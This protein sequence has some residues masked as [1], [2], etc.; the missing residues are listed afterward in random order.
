MFPFP[1]SLRSMPDRHSQ[2]VTSQAVIQ[3]H[4]TSPTNPT[5]YEKSLAASVYEALIAEHQ[6]R[7]TSEQSFVEL[8]A[9]ARWRQMRTWTMQTAALETG[10]AHQ[11]ENAGNSDPVRAALAFQNLADTSNALELLQRYE[12]SFE[13]QYN[14]SLNLLL[15]LRALQPAPV[16]PPHR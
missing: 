9:I 1:P 11:P 15:K 6:P 7:T 3:S 5:L 16:N 2:P 4:A 8:M 14:R 10:M 12:T 13:L